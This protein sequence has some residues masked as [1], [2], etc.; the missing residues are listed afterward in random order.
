MV[1][2]AIITQL[3]LSNNK[4]QVRMPLLDGIENSPDSPINSEDLCWASIM[5]IPGIEISYSVGDIV[6]VGFEDNN[7]GKPIVL[8]Y[9][10]LRGKN[11]DSKIYLKAKEVIAENKFSSSINTTIGN[12]QYGD[13]FT[14]VDNSKKPEKA[15]KK[16]K[17]KGTKKK[18]V[19][20]KEEV[21]TATGSDGAKSFLDYV[22]SLKG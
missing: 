2:R 16:S 11:I 1:T 18:V 20:A 12:I 8:G 5:Y 19:K 14:V 3:D 17:S 15:A 21:K 10:K 4:V 6:I 13:L 9:L 7:V 22:N